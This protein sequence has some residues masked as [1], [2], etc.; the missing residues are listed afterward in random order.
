MRT[1]LLP[2]VGTIL[3]VSACAPKTVPAPIVTSPKF[4]DFL[5]PAIPPAYDNTEAA[6]GED[7]GWRFLQAGDLKNAEREFSTTLKAAPAFF[8]AEAALGYVEL[9]RKDPKAALGHFD[10]VATQQA[11][12]ASALAG[13]GQALLGL[14]RDADAAAAFEAA[15]AADPSLTDLRRRVDVLKFRG[16]QQSLA[17]AREAARAGKADDA[18]HA[19]SAALASSPDSPFLYRELAAVERKKGDS[20][21]ALAHFQKAVAL[22]P[23][24]AHSF[25]QIGD[26]LE[27][28][29]DDQ[30]AATAYASASA[31][32]PTAAL[33]KKIDALRD[34]MALAALPAEYRAIDESPQVTRADLAALIGV[35]LAPLLQTHRQDAVLITDVRTSWAATWIIAVARAGVMEPFSNHAFQPRAIVRRTD[36]AQAV[37]RVLSRI[38]AGNP[39]QAKAW[40]S[41]RG[42]FSD[43]TAGHLAYPAASAAVAAG[44]IT[45]GA[46]RAFQPSRPVTG[47]EA[48]DAVGRLEA[49]AHL[50]PSRS[51]RR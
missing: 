1:W 34:K 28:R 47:A 14:N 11:G 29:N 40:E 32:E 42:S 50:P 25:E 17:S 51:G 31:I 36:L 12:Y 8:P 18:I 44:V 6:A 2:I 27:S 5:A 23:S 39:A 16:L 33:T 7:R 37:V 19:Y 38:A 4:P 49:L 3:L 22:D 21:D 48:L 45:V 15:V 9:A 20:D 41:A 10:R 35:H 13:R 43:L 30:G 46:D 24:D 26:I